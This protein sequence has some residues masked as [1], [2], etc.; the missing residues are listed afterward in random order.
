[1]YEGSEPNSCSP[2]KKEYM[3]RSKSA[4]IAVQSTDLGERAAANED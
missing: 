2:P 4:S 1:M 3:I